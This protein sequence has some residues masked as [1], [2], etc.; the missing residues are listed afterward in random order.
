GTIASYRV[1]SSRG[2]CNACF[3]WVT[4]YFRPG[5]GTRQNLRTAIAPHRCLAD[6]D[7]AA[8]AHVSGD[9]PSI[10][11]D[12]DRVS[13]VVALGQLKKLDEPRIG[14]PHPRRVGAPIKE[15]YATDDLA[16]IRGHPARDIGASHPVE[17]SMFH[18]ALTINRARTSRTRESRRG[19]KWWRQRQ[20]R[21]RDRRD[22]RP[23]RIP[24][25]N[26]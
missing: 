21:G 13:S 4:T 19:H 16:P 5:I 14:R 6:A 25:H 20:G 26:Y 8:G 22:R 10:T 2:G 12:S 7:A 9:Q 24:L 11:G 17:A 23:A 3:Q 1:G 18:L 15:D